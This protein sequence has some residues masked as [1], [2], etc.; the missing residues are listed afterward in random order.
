MDFVQKIAQLFGSA[1]NSPEIAD[2]LAT[3]PTHR[4]QEQRDGCQY[5]VSKEGGFDLLFEETPDAPRRLPQYRVLVAAFLYSDGADQ[6]KAFFDQLPLDFSFQD[7]R[8]DLHAKRAPDMTWV[9]GRGRVQ[10]SYP[11]PSSDAW[12]TTE[13]NLHARFRDDKRVYSFQILPPRPLPQKWHHPPGR[14]WP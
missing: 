7:S 5:L 4:I 14:N 12:Q 11:D 9:I 10:A 3:L 2:F 6:H 13:F 8:Q 1:I